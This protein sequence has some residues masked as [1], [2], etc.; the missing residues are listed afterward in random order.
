LTYP[1]ILEDF[2]EIVTTPSHSRSERAVAD[3][4]KSKLEALGCQVE[5]DG[6]GA[7]IGGDTG[8]LIARLAGTKKGV[9]SV[10]FSAHLDR[11][12]NPGKITPIVKLDQDV[13][14]S[15]GTT[16]LGADDASGLAA[17]LD[18]L[19]RIKQSGLEHGDI[20]LVLTV[21]EEVG[22][23]GSSQIDYGSLKSKIAY[24]ID[25]SGDVGVLVNQAPTQKT[26]WVTIHGVSSHA[27]MEPE[28]GINAIKVGAVALSRLREGRLSPISTSNFGVISG[29]KATN[30]VCDLLKIKGEARSHDEGELSA[31]CRE[32]EETFT[33]AAKEAGAT[34]EFSW[35]NEY[36]AFH[37]L[38]DDTVVKIASEALS[39][40]G[41]KPQIVCGGGG[42]DANN[43]NLQGIKSLGLSP[44]YQK[45][46]SPN[47]A[48]PI[49]QLELT[50]QAV[51]EI[52]KKIAAG[53]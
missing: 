40:L 48:Q 52:I 1:P 37:L 18:G 51:F 3:L 35:T 2:L 12:D 28:K 38:K 29:G 32:I 14:V 24:V 53:N 6:T 44:G 39:S 20:E 45:V 19:R 41:L 4:I 5:E 17:I 21:A 42:L 27:G 22:L 36:Q 46:H 34:V 8:N 31:Y 43:F 30:I 23:K 49:S 11:V 9:E 10:L 16:I 7:K 33:Q 47:E 15:D 26:V 50:G 25:C 13:V